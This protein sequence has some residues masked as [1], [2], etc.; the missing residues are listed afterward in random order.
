MAGRRFLLLP[1]PLLSSPDTEDSAAALCLYKTEGDCVMKFTYSEHANGKS[2]LTALKEPG[3]C[4][5][6][7]PSGAPAGV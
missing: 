6:P 2:V 3:Q 5:V 7:A 1:S 4:V